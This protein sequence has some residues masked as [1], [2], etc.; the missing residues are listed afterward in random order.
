MKSLVIGAGEVGSAIYE[1]IKDFHKSFIR[2]I[3]EI[4]E[5]DFEVIHICYPDHDGFVKTTKKYIEK[6]NPKLTIVHSSIKVGTT[7][8]LGNHVVYS[9]VRGRHPNLAPEIRVYDKFISGRD[10]EDI[11]LASKYFLAC[12]LNVITDDNPVNLEMMK[13]LSN[14]HMGVE[15]AWRQEV[16]RI[17][18]Q[19]KCDP[20][21]YNAWELSYANGYKALKQEHL[22]RPRMRPDPIGGHC[23]LECTEILSDQYPSKIFDFIRQSNEK[24]KKE[25]ED[26]A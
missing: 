8:Q 26:N 17:L 23:I 11:V 7:D 6:Y 3:E 10:T 12:K 18:K 1:V 16:A 4:E 15:I 25:R 14:I 21:I 20:Y 2:D 19:F 5:K 24:S 22:M 13:L 9:P